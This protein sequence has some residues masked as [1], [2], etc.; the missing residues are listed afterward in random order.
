MGECP[1]YRPTIISEIGSKGG[2]EKWK[3]DRS[4]GEYLRAENSAEVVMW[5]V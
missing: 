4:K 1:K 5:G 2:Q 3:V